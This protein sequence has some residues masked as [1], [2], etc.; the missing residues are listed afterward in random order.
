MPVKFIRVNKDGV[1]A[2]FACGLANTHQTVTKCGKP[3][4]R[5]EIEIK[6][7][8]NYITRSNR[9][10]RHTRSPDARRGREIDGR[11]RHAS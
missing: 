6:E 3:L 8:K 4:N 1:G 5:D 10:A 9:C 11:A 2:I 7:S